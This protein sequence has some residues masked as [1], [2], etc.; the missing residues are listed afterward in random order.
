M[1]LEQLLQRNDVWRGR[2]HAPSRSGLLSTGFPLLD[3]ELPG[4]GWPRGALIEIMPRTTGIGELSL[5]LPTLARLVDDRRW[6]AWID[7]PYIP[8][9]PALAAAGIELSRVLC[10][11]SREPGEG[12]WALEQ[13]GQ[14]PECR[15][16]SLHR[17]Q[18]ATP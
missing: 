18:K 9:A 5:L 15:G 6:L 4:G 16:R 17:R 2:R 8:Y 7:P 13:A 10:V 1:S 3:A 11:K 14:A 12:L